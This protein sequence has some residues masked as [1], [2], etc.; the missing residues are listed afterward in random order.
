MGR[1]NGKL[2]CWARQWL[3]AATAEEQG[4]RITAY[5][6][7]IEAG[8]LVSFHGGHEDLDEMARIVL[9]LAETGKLAGVGTDPYGIKK[10]AE[11]L[12]ANGV[13]VVGVKQGWQLS[14]HVA[15][16]ERA[17]RD[18]ELVHCGQPVLRWN[19]ANC[20]ATR[21]GNAVTI[22]KERSRAGGKMRPTSI[23]GLIAL[24]CAFALQ[25][26]EQ[27]P[28]IYEDAAARPEGLIFL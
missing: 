14:P 21:R 13:E 12:E 28:L 24:V 5:G 1:R 25:D 10:L 17:I 9:E 2:A 6:D 3:N 26:E 23:D 8:D 27:G 15:A 18:G 20:I 22:Q 19:V 11:Y 7:F 16:L 4:G